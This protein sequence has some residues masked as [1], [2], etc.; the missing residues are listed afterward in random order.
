MIDDFEGK[1]PYSFDHH[2][3]GHF[4]SDVNGTWMTAEHFSQCL[5]YEGLG[6][7]GIHASRDEQANE[8]KTASIMIYIRRKAH[9]YQSWLEWSL[10]RPAIGK[11]RGLFRHAYLNTATK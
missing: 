2:C 9:E 7:K 11:L 1:T 10:I 5:T 6:W 8:S 4:D 3:A